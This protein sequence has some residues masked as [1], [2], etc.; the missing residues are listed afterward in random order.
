M[1]IT[2]NL[3]VFKPYLPDALFSGRELGDPATVR[4]VP[5]AVPETVEPPGNDQSPR[6]D[7]SESSRDSS[8]I[9]TPLLPLILR[10][11]YIV[12]PK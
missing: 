7:D 5:V 10:T 4:S 3:E 2:T 11:S 8:P 6:H 1:Q 12:Y 9:Q